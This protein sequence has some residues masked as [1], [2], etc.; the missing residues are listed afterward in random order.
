MGPKRIFISKAISPLIGVKKKVTRTKGYLYIFV[1]VIT[2]FIT[3]RAHLVLHL[4]V[5]IMKY[6]EIVSPPK[7]EEDWSVTNTEDFIVNVVLKFQLLL[8]GITFFTFRCDSH[9][10]HGSGRFTYISHKTQPFM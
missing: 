7:Y 6:F 2:P 10:I 1:W 8:I 5:E 9:T 4:D 3:G